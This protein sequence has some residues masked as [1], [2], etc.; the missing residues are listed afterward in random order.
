[1][2]RLLRSRVR[3][4]ALTVEGAMD[5]LGDIGASVGIRS[6]DRWS[7]GREEGGRAKEGLIGNPE[8]GG[9]GLLC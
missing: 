2:G 4:E 5:G 7:A 3:D 6:A 1:M 8:G 9:G